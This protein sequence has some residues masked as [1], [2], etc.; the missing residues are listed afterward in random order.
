MKLKISM[1]NKMTNKQLKSA[2][3]KLGFTIKEMCEALNTPYG[4]YVKWERGERRV[5]G[6]IEPAIKCLKERMEG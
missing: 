6:I 5:P 4:T 1:E 3:K 2:R